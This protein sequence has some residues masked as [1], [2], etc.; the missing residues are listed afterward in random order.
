MSWTCKVWVLDLLSEINDTFVLLEITTKI[1]ASRMIESISPFKIKPYVGPYEPALH[2][3]EKKSYVS[4]NWR[5]RKENSLQIT[6]GLKL[7]Y[8]QSD[9]TWPSIFYQEKT[10]IC[11]L[12]RL[13]VRSVTISL[14]KH[15][16]Q[17][18][19]CQKYK[20][21]LNKWSSPSSV[22]WTS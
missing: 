14:S 17:S 10:M 22:L 19:V 12:S 13:C 2:L 20:N 21:F 11:K 7:T 5:G 8:K 16:F 15:V 6:Q 3:P 18:W 1:S 4:S 9:R